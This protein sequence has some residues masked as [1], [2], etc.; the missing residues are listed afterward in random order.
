MRGEPNIRM[1]L[2]SLEELSSQE[3]QVRLWL[4]TGAHGAE[5]SSPTEAICALFDDSGLADALDW[6]WDE[7]QGGR[8][9]PD[10]PV[11][12]VEVDEQIEALRKM[13]KKLPAGSPQQVIDSPMM[14]EVRTAAARLWSDLSQAGTTG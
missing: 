5:V 10:I 1:I 14:R 4:S 9:V 6:S 13:L 7:R 3:Q 11:Y 8:E 2:D 12:N